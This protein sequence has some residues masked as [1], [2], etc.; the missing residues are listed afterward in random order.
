VL[1]GLFAVSLLCY[2]ALHR[3]QPEWAF[4]LLPARAW[5][6][7]AGSILANW[8]GRRFRLHYVGFILIAISFLGS[9]SVIFAVAGTACLLLSGSD[10]VL[11]SKL[12]VLVGRMSYSLYLWHWPVFSLVDYQFYWQPLYVRMALKIL[13]SFGAAA[14][15]FA[16]LERPG[17]IFLNRPASRRLAFAA[18]ACSLVTL[19]PLGMVVR[20]ANYVN[21]DARAIRH[22]GL[23]FN[24]AGRNGSM[25]LMGDSNGSMYGK[26]A[27]EIARERDLR[28]D[29]ISVEAGDPL[30][31]SAVPNPPLWL[32][33][34]AIVKKE[35]PDF[36]VFVCKWDKLRDDRNRLTL[37]LRELKPYAR[38]VFLITQPPVL[39][40]TAS[41]EGIR[42][43]NRPPFLEN[44]E[45]RASR[46]ER[47][48]LVK[49]AQG[50]NVKTVDIEPLFSRDGGEIRFVDSR[51]R[52]LY[53]DR[54]HL[55]VAGAS[56]VKPKLIEAMGSLTASR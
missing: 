45:E 15:S 54:D 33:S 1:A 22:G 38:F 48:E 23:R 20:N 9:Q 52:Q 17:R 55:S 53:Q 10:G 18:L 34:L 37:A 19:I 41:R 30:P 8:R 40:E 43:G 35:K 6:L 56:L 50:D 24:P 14:A 36:L 39:P 31:N 49:S 44:A 7:L 32:D 4:Y 26:M 29:V 13:I 42:K 11:S 21:A 47:N 46:M 28:L 16:L 3:V 27:L 2:V 25:I 12:L 51:R 5:E